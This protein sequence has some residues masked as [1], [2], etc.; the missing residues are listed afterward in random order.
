M[1]KEEENTLASKLFDII[2]RQHL[3]DAF[4]EGV[5][6]ANRLAEDATVE[7][8]TLRAENAYRTAGLHSDA[9]ASARCLGRAIVLRTHADAAR[10][11]L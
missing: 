8:L 9:R 7:E 11:C 4:F 6:D 1:T 10:A 5:C 2:F 3:E